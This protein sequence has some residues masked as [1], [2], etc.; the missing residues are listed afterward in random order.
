MKHNRGSTCSINHSGGSVLRP[1]AAENH[2]RGP[3]QSVIAAD[4]NVS[5]SV[6]VHAGL[7]SQWGFR[8]GGEVFQSQSYLLIMGFNNT[9]GN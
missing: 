9:A 8:A 4:A 2:V 1:Y 5:L 3:L 6:L 7:R